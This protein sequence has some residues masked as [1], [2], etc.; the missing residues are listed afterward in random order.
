M[1]KN[2][3]TFAF[4]EGDENRVHVTIRRSEEDI[5]IQLCVK[6]ITILREL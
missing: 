1:E 3:D 6:A 4:N 5:M 2:F